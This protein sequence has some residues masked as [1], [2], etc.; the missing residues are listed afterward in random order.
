MRRVLMVLFPVFAVL[1]QAITIGDPGG[2]S[3]LPCGC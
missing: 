1:A 3:I 2:Q